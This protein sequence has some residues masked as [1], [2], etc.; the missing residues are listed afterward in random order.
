MKKIAFLSAALLVLP[1]LVFAQYTSPIS[2]K[3]VLDLIEILLKF[4]QVIAVP[5]AA[6]GILIASFFYITSMG[7]PGRLGQAKSA[8]LY[9]V[10]GLVI[11]LSAQ[12]L[13]DVVIAI[14]QG[15]ST[16]KSFVG[17]I[18]NLANAFGQILFG[19][20]VLAMLYAAFL[21]LTGGS[22]EKQRIQA[23]QV[24]TFAVVG[25]IVALLAFAIPEFVKI[26]VN[27]TISP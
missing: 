14:A 11:A 23:K 4:V 9:S 10:I 17:F 1:A 7:D 22:D 16:A 25:L 15:A 3:S 27:R 26:I 13:V 19:L 12:F 24:I 21:F 8:I 20:A 5:L 18:N 2:A 6:I